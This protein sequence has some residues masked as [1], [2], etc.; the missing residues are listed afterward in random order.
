VEVKEIRFAFVGFGNI[1][2]T[3]MVALK[4][5]PILK[6]LPFVPVLD[7]LITRDPEGN[8]GQATAIG[9]AHVHSSLEAALQE[10]QIDVV[11][12]CTPNALHSDPFLT[13]LKAGKAIYCEKPLTDQYPRSKALADAAG[14]DNRHQVALVYR[15][16]PAVIRMKE[17][18]QRK[19]IGQVLQCRLS[20]R[21]SGYLN[22]ARPVSWRLDEAL[23]GG[24]AISDLG[25]HVIDLANYLC[26]EIKTV[27]GSVNTFVK[28]RPAS[29]TDSTPVEMKVDDWASMELEHAGGVRSIAEVSRVAWGIEAFQVDITGTK[30]GI[31]CDLEKEYLPRVRLLDG[32]S[33]GTVSPEALALGTDDKSTLGMSVDCHFSALHHFLQRLTGN[34]P[35]EDGLAPTIEDCLRAEYWIQ[36]VLRQNGRDLI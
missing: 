13:A 34:S 12:I 3:H 8:R 10:R 15:Y 27:N 30:G 31:S 36:E 6:K 14:A 4:A 17:L 5:M 35:Y 18:L 21:R 19:V 9:F 26:G 1:A 23:T 16:H 11:D 25:V 32:S 20:Y 28:H 24:G 29:F 2:K 33:P 7:T 22:A